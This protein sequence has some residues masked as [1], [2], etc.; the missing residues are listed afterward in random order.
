MLNVRGGDVECN[1]VALSYGYIGE[2]ENILFIQKEA[3]C[4]E[5]E[6]YLQNFPYWQVLWG[7]SPPFSAPWDFSLPPL[8]HPLLPFC[9]DSSCNA[10]Y[11]A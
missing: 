4:E 9:K 2:E 8:W 3:L 6:K 7:F 1:P 5:T 10:F 11:P